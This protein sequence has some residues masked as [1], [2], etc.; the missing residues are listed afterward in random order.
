M[1][2]T[3]ESILDD[4]WRLPPAERVAALSRA[5]DLADAAGDLD[6]GFEAR[7]R[8]V[9]ASYYVPGSI[10]LISAYS[11]LIARSDEDSQRFNVN[12]WSYKW[13]VH[14]L[15]SLV[16]VS[17]SQIES[18]LDDLGRRFEAAGE[19]PAAYAKLRLTV[20]MGMGDIDQLRPA[21]IEWRTARENRR[22]WLN[23]CAA[24][25]ESTHTDALV[26]LGEDRE[27]LAAANRLITDKSWCSDQP[28]WTYP[29]L[30]AP[31]RRLGERELATDLRKRG[32]KLVRDNRKFLSTI[33]PFIRD[34][35]SQG[36]LDRA[37]ALVAKHR[38]W[39]D[40]NDD[41]DRLSF[42]SAARLVALR[43]DHIGKP[44]PDSWAD[45][46]TGGRN[47]REVGD[48]FI[49]DAEDLG[50]RFDARNG[51]GWFSE[52]LANDLAFAQR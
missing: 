31:A 22:G 27:A 28:H 43:F 32:Y 15:P 44:L 8:M 49:A 47:A 20:A 50:Q 34:S 13:V 18:V 33:G 2:E 19:G 4:C 35:M 7:E 10:D 9:S 17:R 1:T 51:N 5:V 26:L 39:L 24:C 52:N 36:D 40:G 3:A 6:L 42:S 21:L 48:A 11:W 23:D 46:K 16:S 37:A 30:I 29:H 38:S 14:A 45:L 41:L 25:D 12:L